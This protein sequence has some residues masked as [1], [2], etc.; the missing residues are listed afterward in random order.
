MHSKKVMPCM[1]LK[2]LLEGSRVDK[3][4]VF[5]NGCFD[6]L[7]IGHIKLLQYAKNIGDILIVGLNS[8]QSIR[9]NKG[10][11]RPIVGEEDRSEILSALYFVDYICI[12]NEPN[13]IHMIEM[14]KP[15]I[16]VKGAEYQKKDILGSHLVDQV[17]RFQMLEKHSTSNLI[18]KI[19]KMSDI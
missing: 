15:N 4:V 12:F 2:I 17:Y 11:L 8:D 3:V 19:Q 18:K 10:Q 1:Q 14:L 5:T 7:H 9:Q 16:L 13:P 6:L